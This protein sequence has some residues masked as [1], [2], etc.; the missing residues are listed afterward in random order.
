MQQNFYPNQSIPLYASVHIPSIDD[1]AYPMSLGTVLESHYGQLCL[2]MQQYIDNK[3]WINNPPALVQVGSPAS[4]HQINKKG[5]KIPVLSPNDVTSRTPYDATGTTPAFIA[6]VRDQ[7]QSAAMTTDSIMGQAAGARTTATEAENTFTM[8][9]SVLAVDIDCFVDMIYGQYAKR[10]Q[11]YARWVDID[12]LRAIS[13]QYGQVLTP[14][15]LA[16]DLGLSTKRGSEFISSLR[17]QG[18]IRYILESTQ[19]GDP[20][21]NRHA[22]VRMLLEEWKF[23]N[24][25]GIVNDNGEALAV[26]Q[27]TEQAIQT[28][29]GMPIMVDPSQNHQIAVSVKTSFIKD[30]ESEWNSNPAYVINAPKLINQIQIH[31]QFI[32]IEALQRQLQVM[33]QSDLDP[34]MT[35]GA[36]QQLQAASNMM[37]QQQQA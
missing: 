11:W 25:A 36:L 7:M 32:Q 2:A 21:I 37:G 35:D 13:G 34:S 29:L 14:Q 27:A 22:L 19:P 10:V 33:Q 16:L 3:D 24:V 18:H 17:R 20:S 26:R 1:G 28:Y 15:M 23:P 5:A 6:G 30:R 4:N 9:T 8:S 31:Q 12:V